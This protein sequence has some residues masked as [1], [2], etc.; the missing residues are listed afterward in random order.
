MNNEGYN[1]LK[2]H[3][4]DKF[5]QIFFI[6]FRKLDVKVFKKML[7]KLLK[8]N[9]LLIKQHKKSSFS[10]WN[11]AAIRTFCSSSKLVGF[12]LDGDKKVVLVA[13][14]ERELEFPFVWLKDNCQCLECFHRNSTR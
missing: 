4:K 12:R 5:I 1:G 9:S 7:K 10:F 8:L 2:K 6:R 13:D 11:V 14:K 3:T